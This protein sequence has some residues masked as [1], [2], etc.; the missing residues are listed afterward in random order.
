MRNLSFPSIF[1]SYNDNIFAVSLKICNNCLLSHYSQV[2]CCFILWNGEIFSTNIHC[3]YCLDN[4]RS[5]KN[6][7]FLII[8]ILL[9]EMNIINLINP[10]FIDCWLKRKFWLSLFVIITFSNPALAWL[11]EFVLSPVKV[12]CRFQRKKFT[13]KNQVSF[14]KIWRK[15]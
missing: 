3:N 5:V 13:K 8:I 10:T 2:C 12:H 9:N 15:K 6:N 11:A 14:C 4:A 1:L 7:Y